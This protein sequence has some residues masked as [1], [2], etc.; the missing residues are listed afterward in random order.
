MKIA[1][2]QN[3]RETAKTVGSV[4]K[5]AG[6]DVECH[7]QG[8]EALKS[9]LQSPPDLVILGL[10]LPVIDGFELCRQI[11]RNEST[12]DL[13]MVVLSDSGD[14]TDR[15]V[16][17]ELGVDD[18]VVAPFSSRELLLRV[19]AILKHKLKTDFSPTSSVVLRCGP[20]ALFHEEHRL[21]ASG[22][23]A[24]LTRTECRLLHLL[25]SRAGRSQHRD[26]LISE[27]WNKPT[28]KNSRLLDVYVY[29]VRKKLGAEAS[30]L[31]T[32]TG[33]GYR[34]AS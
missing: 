1:I 25:M 3:C 20:V 8:N 5:G 4:L 21:V 16:A 9:I 7:R 6:Y 33:F 31:E 22:E 18:F 23:E 26:S 30:R 2:A 13:P 34:F 10:H 27:I 17:Y 24:I 14:A 15:I 32:V 12:T 28:A 11:R 29:R 19:R